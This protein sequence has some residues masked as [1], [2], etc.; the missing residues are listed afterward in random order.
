MYRLREDRSFCSHHFKIPLS[1]GK[2]LV[3]QAA[4]LDHVSVATKCCFFCTISKGSYTVS[5][6]Q[7]LCGTI[8]GF[9]RGWTVSLVTE[10]FFLWLI[11]Q[12]QGDQLKWKSRLCGILPTRKMSI[13][14]Y[15][16]L[17]LRKRLTPNFKNLKKSWIH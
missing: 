4:S 13:N 7:V 17:T 10:D 8:L 6:I 3:F 11:R 5:C 15:R 2:R 12:G 1:R 14:N 16:N 9:V